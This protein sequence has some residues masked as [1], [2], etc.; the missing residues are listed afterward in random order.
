MLL[1]PLISVILLIL[2]LLIVRPEKEERVLRQP[3][4][5]EP[6]Q[7]HLLRHDHVLHDLVDFDFELAALEV[8]DEDVV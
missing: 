4:Y 7:L 6:D 2:A 1:R 5:L 8:V 3:R